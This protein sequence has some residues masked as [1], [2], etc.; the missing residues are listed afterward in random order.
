M[1]KIMFKGVHFKFPGVTHDRIF[2]VLYSLFMQSLRF[3]ER[4]LWTNDW[5]LRLQAKHTW[6]EVWYLSNRNCSWTRR[7]HGW[8]VSSL[9]FNCRL[10]VIPSKLMDLSFLFTKNNSVIRRQ[11]WFKLEEKFPVRRP[12]TFP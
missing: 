8:W 5:T 4:W 3:G 9:N 1:K 2:I 6:N 7:M 12:V 10:L 11:F